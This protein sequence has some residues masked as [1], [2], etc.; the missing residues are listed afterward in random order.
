MTSCSATKQFLPED[1]N[2]PFVAYGIFRPGQIAYHQLK[3]F[4]GVVEKVF[5]PGTLRMRDGL[6]LFDESRDGSGIDAYKISFLRGREESAYSVISEMEPENLFKWGTVQINGE[7]CNILFGKKVKRGSHEIDFK[8]YEDVWNDPLFNSALSVV[9]DE[10]PDIANDRP[11]AEWDMRAF[12]RLQMA[13]LLL[14]SAIERFATLRYGFGHSPTKKLEML[15]NDAAFRKA[16]MDRVNEGNYFDV[17]RTDD[18]E[19]RYEHKPDNPLSAMLA[20][21]QVRSNITHRGKSYKND[22]IR[23]VKAANTLFLVFHDVLD[24]AKNEALLDMSEI[25]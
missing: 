15:A 20:Y 4:V 7:A 21:Y 2:R 10:L 25:K 16:I 12:F 18:P 17:F 1:R 6:V 19:K 5:I 24:A 13:Y 11:V 22:Y 23:L 8:E 3:D 14:W 9:C